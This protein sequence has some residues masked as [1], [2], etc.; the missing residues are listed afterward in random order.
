MVNY[1]EPNFQDIIFEPIRVG[2]ITQ[3]Q[4][5]DHLKNCH[6]LGRTPYCRI[7]QQSPCIM[8]RP[9]ALVLVLSIEIESHSSNKILGNNKQQSTYIMIIAGTC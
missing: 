6:F 3:K 1:I 9:F 7:I 5:W 2:L 4:F 8:V